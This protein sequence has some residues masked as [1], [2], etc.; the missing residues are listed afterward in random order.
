MLVQHLVQ[1]PSKDQAPR[2]RGLVYPGFVPASRP[3]PQVPAPP[4]EALQSLAPNVAHPGQGPVNQVQDLDKTT[5]CTT[6][7]ESLNS[8]GIL[9]QTPTC[10]QDGVPSKAQAKT[11]FKR[12]SQSR[13]LSGPVTPDQ[14]KA[15]KK[16]HLHDVLRLIR[17]HS[18]KESVFPIGECII[19]VCFILKNLKINGPN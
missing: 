19:E 14:I 17:E 4:Q 3:K 2:N 16:L 9:N 18:P 13:L 15:L 11:A 7:A 12:P 10:S 5:P 6:Q 8:N 1:V